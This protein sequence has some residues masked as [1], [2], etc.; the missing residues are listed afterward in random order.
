MQHRNSYRVVLAVF[1]VLLFFSLWSCNKEPKSKEFVI[2]FSQCVESDAWRKTM[3]EEMKRELSFYP[4]V[5]FLYRDAD[6][7][8]ERQISQVKELVRKGIDLLIISPNEAAPLT[9]VVEETFRKGTPVIVVD[10]KISSPSYTAYVGGDNYNIGRMAGEYTV[11]LLKGRGSVVEITGLPKSTPAM[12]RD[13]GF[14]DALRPYPS[15]QVERLNGEWY[16]TK[17]KERLAEIAGKA[18]VDLVFAQNDMMASGTYEVFQSKGLPVPK[19]IGVDGLPCSG[20]GMEFVGN[21]LVTATMLYPT[22]GEDAIQTALK[23]LNK[24]NFEKENVIQ[25]T[26]IDSTNVRYMKLQADKMSSQQR[27]IERQRTLLDEMKTITNH[28]RTFLYIL[29]SSLVLAL[30]FGGVLFYLF[31]QNRKINQKLQEQNKAILL[32]KEELE[33]MSAKAQVANEAKVSFFTNISHEFR[34]PLTLILAPLEE[35]LADA[36]NNQRWSRNLQ[37]VHKNVIRLLRL[38]NQLMDFRKIE[39]EKMRLRAS[40]NDLI[41]F[42]NEILQ[43]YERIAQKRGIDLR[44]LT[45][46]RSLPVW[47][48][49]NMLDK[50]LFNLLS[51]AFKFT[52]DGGLIH[53]Y[54]NRSADNKEVVI[55][56]EDNGVGMT[57]DAVKNVFNVFYQGEFENQKGSG[58]GLALSKELITL[59]KGSIAVESRKRQGTTFT[60]RL[61]LGKD[62]LKPEEIIE[63]ASAPFVLYEDEKVYTTDLVNESAKQEPEGLKLEKEHTLLLIEDNEDLRKFLKQRLQSHYEVV[64]AFDGQSALQ[65]AFDVVPDL[66]VTD[67]IIPGKDGMALTNILKSDIRTS[68]IPV[69]MLTGK[70]NMESQ[71]EGLK[72]RADAYITKPFN[73]E[74]LETTIEC[75]LANR[76]M[77]KEHY[78]AELPSNLKTQTVAK[79]DRKFISDFTAIVESNLANEDFTIEDICKDLGISRVQLYRKVKALMNVNV[80]DYI[81]STRLQKARYLLQ[82]EELSISEISFKVGFSSPAYFSTVFKSK[83][84]VTP[85]AFKEK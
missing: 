74:F 38:V 17:A 21:K 62:H 4:N 16:K 71:L 58:L 47:F 61:P 70:T 33:D 51:N 82:H 73:I 66:I 42:T 36:K 44:L 24:E 65:Q 34:T 72:N 75:M 19:I 35:M 11:N 5:T 23:I 25:T 30:T 22:G 9:P 67:V 13:R 2:G 18:P 81:L 26:V 32:Q 60:I 79:I 78:S 76:V 69:V 37:L 41:L 29:I 28:Q 57:E 56:V 3:L 43:S 49:V 84:G 6:G 40:E 53:V 10:R 20:C 7:N 68:H 45:N 59:H 31:R 14:S 12:E 80:N 39:V 52:R 54:V 77:L 15:I 50:V 64:E 83:F 8:S 85:K 55:K 1:Q 27:S 48:D 63:A 46:E